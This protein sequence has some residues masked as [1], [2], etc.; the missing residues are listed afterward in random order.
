MTVLIHLKNAND[1]R[2]TVSRKISPHTVAHIE[3]AI[4][5]MVMDTNISEEHEKYGPWTF[6]NYSFS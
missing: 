5:Y 4:Q 1:E 6:V 2:L 3:D